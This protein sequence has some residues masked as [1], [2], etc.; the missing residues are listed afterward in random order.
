MVGYLYCSSDETMKFV[1][2]ITAAIVGIF[3]LFFITGIEAAANLGSAKKRRAYAMIAISQLSQTEQKL[4]MNIFRAHKQKDIKTVNEVANTADHETITSLLKTFSLENRPPQFSS[5][6]FGDTLFSTTTE[7]SYIEAGY[8]TVASKLIT[9]IMVHDL[10][11]A[12]KD[13][14][15]ST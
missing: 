1:I 3:I 8:S 7:K 2:I 14:T 5:G 11:S 12:L 4:L 9:S 10:D 13:M 15:E 6:K